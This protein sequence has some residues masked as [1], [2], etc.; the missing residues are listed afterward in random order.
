MI[1]DITS[2]CFIFA[3]IVEEILGKIKHRK[4]FQIGQL[5]RQLL[6]TKDSKDYKCSVLLFIHSYSF[7]GVKIDISR[8]SDNEYMFRFMHIYIIY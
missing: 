4:K 1:T 3:V 6:T 8:I 7:C 2:A 5:L